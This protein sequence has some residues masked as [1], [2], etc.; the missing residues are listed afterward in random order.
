MPHRY[1]WA[2]GPGKLDSLDKRY[3]W[4]HQRV[5]LDTQPGLPPMS[6]EP[7]PPH[8]WPY[9]MLAPHGL[10]VP[11]P[12]ALLNGGTEQELLLLDAA[13]ITAPL[14][15]QDKP[16]LLPSLVDS[17]PS[18]SPLRQLNWL[19][20]LAGL[21]SDFVEHRVASSLLISERLRVNGSIVRLLDLAVDTNPLQLKNLGTS[22]QSLVS[23]A[24]AS[25]RDF[26]GSLCT[27]LIQGEI[28]APEVLVSCLDQAIAE[29]SSGYQVDCQLSVM[30][31]QG[32][33]R[34]RN[35]DACYPTSGAT[36]T[37]TAGPKQKSGSQSPLLLL[38]CDGI[39]GHEG[40]DVAS[41]LA[42]SSIHQELMPLME[43]LSDQPAHDPAT[44]TLA[45]EQAVYAAN[46]QISLHNDQGARQARDRMGTT[47]VLALVFGLHIYIA[48]V[49][50]S[51]AYRISA[52]NCRQI[53]FDDD[54]AAREVRLGYG[55]YADIVNRPGTGA[56]IQALGMGHSTALHVVVQRLVL[57]EDIALLLCSDGLSDYDRIEQFWQTQLLP[58]ATGHAKPATAVADLVQ[59]ANTYNGHD[60][61]TVGVVAGRIQS[62]KPPI[63]SAPSPIESAASIPALTKTRVATS[64]AQIPVAVQESPSPAKKR[65]G[66]FWLFFIGLI[67]ALGT[68]TVLTMLFVN[69]SP[70]ALK[71]PPLPEAAPDSEIVGISDGETAPPSLVPGNFLQLS[72]PLTLL[73][74][75]QTD[76]DDNE[77]G[78]L[79]EGTV[80]Q[81]LTRQDTAGDQ[82]RWVKLK[83]CDLSLDSQAGGLPAAGQEPLTP[84]S[85]DVTSSELTSL[86][87][88]IEG[89]VL[90][91]ELA[92]I[93]RAAEGLTCSSE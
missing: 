68:A 60:N 37:H 41:Q 63:V 66:G 47:V 62:V 76:G 12:Y 2:V 19:W 75:P 35:E 8:V 39:G 53:T 61:V 93:S 80:V 5:V 55:F 79:P 27:Q 33:S 16:Q 44:I 20:Q 56:L 30:T 26:L 45:I 54:V 31:H 23:Q 91:S 49:G 92:S 58:V 67:T 50:D 69:E 17:W 38:V 70:I 84:S 88:G 48:H 4:Q 71:S 24:H 14:G 42:I 59:L 28:A 15:Q 65:G 10:H 6:P 43:W 81:V 86:L 11:Q 21:W 18:V 57:D 64:T 87:S 89:W 3:S 22:W 9:L 82:S 90:E 34:K 36:Q 1:L 83:T 46:D 52:N 25:I 7:V 74:L 85:T 73:T 77:L 32:P 29:I 78:Q 13:A 51:R 72:Q 40:G